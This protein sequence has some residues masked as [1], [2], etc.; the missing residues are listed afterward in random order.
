MRL[1]FALSLTCLAGPAFGQACH[2]ITQLTAGLLSGYGEV[3]ALTLSAPLILTE[4]GF[5]RVV[6]FLNP[7]GGTWT[8][9]AVRPEGCG[10]N[11][12]GGGA[13]HVP[14]PAVAGEDG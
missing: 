8:L 14:A 10:V 5:D 7:E 3:P 4:R 12:E 2:D 6:M 13:W 9:V 11:V 1:K